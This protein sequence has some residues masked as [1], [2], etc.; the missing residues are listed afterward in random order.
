MENVKIQLWETTFFHFCRHGCP[1]KEAIETK[2]ACLP[3]YHEK[4]LHIFI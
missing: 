1:E 2:F 3:F 4:D